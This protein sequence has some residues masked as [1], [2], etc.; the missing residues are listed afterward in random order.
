MAARSL[1]P[2]VEQF[3]PHEDEERLAG[4]GFTAA[5]LAA[6]AAAAHFPNSVP[7]SISAIH[8][9]G[10]TLEGIL[11]SSFLG[12]SAVVVIKEHHAN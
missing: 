1:V 8:D 5:S 9:F 3:V 4:V 6:M 7:A 10:S 12:S 2:K 11:E